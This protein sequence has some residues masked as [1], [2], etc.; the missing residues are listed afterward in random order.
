PSATAPTRC[1][2]PKAPRPIDAVVGEA[3]SERCLLFHG[4]A[5][6]S[7]HQV[8]DAMPGISESTVRRL[9]HYYRTLEE[10]EAEGGRTLSS[11]RLAERG[12]ITPAQVRKDLSAFGSFGR[13]GLGYN[14]AYL[15]QE[16]R[17]ILGLDR[18]WRVAVVGAGRVGTALSSYPGVGR[19]GVDIVAMLDVGPPRVGRR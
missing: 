4:L 10:V 13:R 14:V 3:A 17:A 18:R 6:E 11:R 19:Q 7:V 8:A 9:S 2:S 12:G 5:C 1:P 16:L 15:R